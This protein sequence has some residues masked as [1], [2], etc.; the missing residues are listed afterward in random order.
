MTES[1]TIQRA[2]IA[3]V[4]LSALPPLGQPLDE[5]TFQGVI[6]TKDGTHMAVVLLDAKPKGRM[7]WKKAMDWADSVGGALPSRP[8]AA[9]LYANA[10]GLFDPTWYWTSDSLEADTGDEDDASFA[11]FC[12]FLDGYQFDYLRKGAEGGAVA[13]RLIPLTA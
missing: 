9:M 6:T 3:A 8:V 5:G 13:V 4:L 2:A 7:T 11:W 12:F 1:T 10:K